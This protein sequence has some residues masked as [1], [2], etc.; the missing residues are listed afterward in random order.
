V[1]QLRDLS[2]VVLVFF[3]LVVPSAASAAK[4]DTDTVVASQ[5]GVSVTLGNVDSFA[6]HIPEK[7]RAEF[8]NSP[9]RIQTLI[10]NL[11]VDKQLA[12][13]AR[14]LGIDRD[15]AVAKELAKAS[16]PVAVLARARMEKLR[17]SIE[18]PDMS[19][20]ALEQYIGHKEDYIEHGR[21]D[22]RDVLVSTAKRSEDEAHTLATTIAEQAEADPAAFPALVTKYSDQ[23]DKAESGGLV[24]HLES[25]GHD[26]MLVAAAGKLSKPGE[27]SRVVR[28]EN[29]FHV[30]QLVARA[31]DRQQSFDEVRQSIVDKLEKDYVAKTLSLH[32]ARLRSQKLDADPAL[33]ASLRTRYAR[34]GEPQPPMQAPGRTPTH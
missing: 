18:V 24:T 30:L 16:D 25:G 32:R 11:L 33:V 34:P 23:A 3:S 28:A 22:V 20:L 10:T 17:K 1:F 9:Q 15:P 7:N 21:I 29:G 5:G 4:S 19:E 26:P 27:V 8:F 31:P 14:K 12:A 13:E 2:L 6:A